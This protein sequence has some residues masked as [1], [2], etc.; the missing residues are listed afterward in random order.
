MALAAPWKLTLDMSK[1]PPE[2]LVALAVRGGA[3]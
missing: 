3:P 1:A 2:V